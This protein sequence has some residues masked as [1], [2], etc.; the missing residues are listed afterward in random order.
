MTT[1]STN[2]LAALMSRNGQ[3]DVAFREL[4]DALGVAVYKT[5]AQG[6]ITYFN[7][8]AVRLFGRVPELGTDSWS[9]A[10]KL[11]LPDG[12][13]LPHDECPMSVALRGE[14]V[15]A[16]V[17]CIAERPD[18]SRLWFTPFPTV[19]RDAAGRITG[20]I[21]VLIDITDRKASEALSRDIARTKEAEQ[22]ALLLA[23][24]VSNSDDAIISK[25]LNGVVTS[26]NRSAEKLF[27]YTAAEAIGHPIAS[28]I[29]PP[30]RQGEETEIL[31]QL[32]RGERVDHF[33]TV[34][35]RK[36]GALLDV[37][38]TISPI[39]NNSGNVVGA[40]KIARDISERKRAEETIETLNAQL[41]SDLAVMTRMQQLSTRS[42]HGDEYSR[43]LGEIIDTAIQ[44]TGADMGDIQLL[45]RGVWTMGAYRG[46]KAPF[47]DFLSAQGGKS[48]W[49][50]AT[51][52][53]ERTIVE[54]VTNS[55]IFT[56][57]P[58]RSAMLGAGVIAVQTTPLIS[59]SGWVVG[60]LSTHYRARHRPAQRDLR[61]LDI[62]ARQTADLIERKRAEDALRT[63]EQ[64]FRQ[65]ADSMPQIVWAARPDGY[66]DY[67][68][69]KWY[70]FTGISR[71]FFGDESWMQVVSPED[72][73][74][75]K[76]AYYS[77]INSGQPFEVEF[78]LWDRDA[79]RFKWFMGRALPMRDEHEQIVKWI[80]T[81]T[82]I[83]DQKRIEE[84]LRRAN[85][86]LEQFAF[87]AS[88]DLREPLRTIKIYSELLQES[89]RGA[90]N[91]QTLEYLKYLQS[92][93]T[94]MEALVR[95]LL[96]YS[97]MTKMETSLEVSDARA[98]LETALANLGATISETGARITSDKL[99]RLPVH[100]LHLQQLFQNLIAN[101]IKFRSPERPPEVHVSAE[102][103]H[104]HWV[105]S[106]IDNGIGIGPE[107][108]EKIFG[109]FKRLHPIDR[110]PGTGIGLAICK[111]IVDRYHGRIWVDS[112]LGRGSAF[113]FTLPI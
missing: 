9:V 90:V 79:N 112:E 60:T 2:A 86:E 84:D 103:Q 3:T 50:E 33:E 102:R 63:S 88:H 27:G 6:R 96:T 14:D 46:F 106:V 83:D 4:V 39:K 10:W 104:D 57:K 49:E 24:I 65:L 52:R 75:T 34:R 108:K 53:G 23:A 89:L 67:Y 19:V 42:I 71:Y 78:R 105:F 62:L 113:R 45:E 98:A 66:V 91:S 97:Q 99:P 51:E 56:G 26:W 25:D 94:R 5:D 21:N 81:C 69:E 12:T 58:S 111:R 80:G 7:Q 32:R 41:G 17:E 107:Y 8:A 38:L 74:R 1:L 68:N 31:E 76:Q 109:L 64:R 101:A 29:I 72:V 28:L 22:T 13:S 61:L 36:D 70:Q 30:D 54:D 11:F 18:G 59:R 35:R 82:G 93:A 20:G 73:E 85:K 95:D 15:P 48:E 92:G 87:S 43:L 77:A 55:P 100:I 47:I 16:G 110:Y 40:S 37:S 44:I